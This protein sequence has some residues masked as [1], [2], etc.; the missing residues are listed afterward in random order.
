M[1]D[2]PVSEAWLASEPCQA[3]QVQVVEEAV[4]QV[5]AGPILHRPTFWG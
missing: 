5:Q 3:F 4:V 1:F 2:S